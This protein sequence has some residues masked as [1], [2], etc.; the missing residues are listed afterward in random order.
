MFKRDLLFW[1]LLLVGGIAIGNILLR[2]DRVRDPKDFRP[3]RMQQ[4]ASVNTTSVNSSAAK[5]EW[6]AKRGNDPGDIADTVRELN[7]EFGTAWTAQ[8]LRHAPQAPNKAIIRRLSLALTGTIPSIAELRHLEKVPTDEQ[9]E[10]WLS[11]LLEDPRFRDYFAER[12][13]RAFVGTD[14]GPLIVYRRS[15]FKH[16]LAEQIKNQTPYDQIVRDLIADT[17]FS[18][19]NPSVNFITSAVLNNE[20]N[21]IDTIRL[22]GRTTRAFLAMRIDCL[23][24]HDD[25]LGNIW[26]GDPENPVDG[27]QK[28]FH[29]LV[30]FYSSAKLGLTGIYDKETTYKFKFLG[31]EEEVAVAPGVPFNAEILAAHGTEREQL[32]QWITSPKNRPFARAAVNRIWAL[33]FGQPL[34][35]PIDDIPI[36]G[37]FAP[38]M[39]LLVDDFIEHN[40]NMQRLI[41][42]ICMCQVFQQDS[43]ADFEI[44][45]AHER[46]WSVFPV[47]RLRPEQM[48]S[49]IV[50]SSSLA[51]IDSTAHIIPR[52]VM[53]GNV[54]DF[55]R[56]YGDI[57][58]DEFKVRAGTI[59]QRLIMMNGELVRERTKENFVQNA[60]T[61]L[62]ALSTSD[63]NT[64]EVAYLAIF[65][66]LPTHEE[67]EYFTKQ[68]SGLK[69]RERREAVEDL[70]WTLLN[71]TEFSWN[72]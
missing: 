46:A 7:E 45:P 2:R 59:P 63:E 34:M 12:F 37:P 24:C 17:G 56:R 21:R 22:A 36:A 49:A 51:T 33:I 1:T 72:H 52:L 61:R 40:Y 19:A 62:A 6:P 70:Y 13:A 27:T 11:Y 47:T 20:D 25:K 58:E 3:D 5:P 9:V 4:A 66:R 23:Q 28:D 71:S 31:T 14:D 16:W 44:L 30:A 39:E 15:R 41:R 38:G 29:K 64:I 43:R 57:G 18:T 10:W 26:L 50:Q 60:S 42:I 53:F 8:K 65:T 54:N 48:A 67:S 32:A 55:V 35:E 69:G 68:L